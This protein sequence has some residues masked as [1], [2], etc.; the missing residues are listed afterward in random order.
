MLRAVVVAAMSRGSYQLLICVSMI[1][2]FI[3]GFVEG[4]RQSRY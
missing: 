2:G 3:K 1:A 4:W